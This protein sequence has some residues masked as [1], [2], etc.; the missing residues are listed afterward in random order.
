MRI[1]IRMSH[2][3]IAEYDHAKAL[4]EYVTIFIREDNRYIRAKNRYAILKQ[5]K[6]KHAM[7]KFAFGMEWER[8]EN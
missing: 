8:T 4:L 1:T 5:P 6:D 7:W 2:E 3:L